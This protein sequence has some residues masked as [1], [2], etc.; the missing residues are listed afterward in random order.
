MYFLTT[1]TKHFCD[2]RAFL[3]TTLVG[4]EIHSGLNEIE[5]NN[6]YNTYYKDIVVLC[7]LIL[8]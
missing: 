6:V 8:Q 1:L 2:K 3:C 4:R 7:H 5:C